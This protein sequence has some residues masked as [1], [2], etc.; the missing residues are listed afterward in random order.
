MVSVW[1]KSLW[2]NL[3][4]ID[5]NNMHA[6]KLII[7]SALTEWVTDISVFMS[8]VSYSLNHFIGTLPQNWSDVEQ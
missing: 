2:K 3:K 5:K 7:M 1:Q 4:I 6:A 8:V